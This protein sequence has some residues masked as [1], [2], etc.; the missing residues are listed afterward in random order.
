MKKA[1]TLQ[2]LDL[3]G[4]GRGGGRRAIIFLGRRRRREGRR[5]AG[6]IIALTALA[7]SRE[8]L[9]ISRERRALEGASSGAYLPKSVEMGRLTAITAMTRNRGA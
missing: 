1:L 6:V 5:A 7:C 3:F 9:G 2:A 4:A 8:K